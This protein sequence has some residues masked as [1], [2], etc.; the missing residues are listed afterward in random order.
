MD[1]FFNRNQI[2]E[3]SNNLRYNTNDYHQNNINVIEDTETQYD[4]KNNFII[5]NSKDRDWINNTNETPYRFS[6]KLGGSHTD[7]YSV[8]TNEYK[9]ISYIEVNKDTISVAIYDNWSY[10]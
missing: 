7:T 2:S 9:N 4:I 3:Q 6:V 1:H 10:I 8:T 5:I